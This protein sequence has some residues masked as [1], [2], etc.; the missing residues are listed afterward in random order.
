M[1]DIEMLNSDERGRDALSAELSLKSDLIPPLIARSSR[2]RDCS[3]E[4]F[5]LLTVQIAHDFIH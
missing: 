2:L 5:S 1:T 3:K 4:Q